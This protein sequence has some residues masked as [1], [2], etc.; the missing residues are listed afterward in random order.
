MAADPLLSD[1]RRWADTVIR[2]ELAAP[3]A[4]TAMRRELGQFPAEFLLLPQADVVLDIVMPDRSRHL[5]RQCKGSLMR[6]RDGDSGVT[7]R[8]FQARHEVAEEAALRDAGRLQARGTVAIAWAVPVSGALPAGRFWNA[9][10]TRTGCV[11]P[12]ILNAPWKLNSDRSALTGE[13]WN[14]ALMRHAASLVARSLPELARKRDPARPVD[15]LPRELERRDDPSAPLH[16]AM[17]REVRCVRFLADGMAGLRR[18]DELHRPPVDDAR[19]Q[20]R[21]EHAASAEQRCA[22]VHHACLRSRDRISRLERLAKLLSPRD[23]R[24]DS[25]E[26]EAPGLPIPAEEAD[27]EAGES[28][29]RL[30][31][32]RSEDWLGAIADAEPQRGKAALLLAADLAEKDPRLRHRL[33]HL[34]IIPTQDDSLAKAEQVVMPGGAVPAGRQAVHPDLVADEAIRDVLSRV[35]RVGT[36]DDDAWRS[37]LQETWRGSAESRPDACERGWESLLAAPD[38]VRQRFLSEHADRLRF[39]TRSGEWK[40]RE[41]VLLPGRVVADTEAAEYPGVLLDPA[42]VERAGALLAAVGVGDRPAERWVREDAVSWTEPAWLVALD[43]K[44]AAVYRERK[45]PRTNPQ[46]GTLGYIRPVAYPAGLGLLSSLKGPSKARLTAVLLERLRTAP[47]RENHV[48]GRGSDPTQNKYPPIP[49]PDPAAWFLWQEGCVQLGQT[50]VTLADVAA[51]QGGLSEEEREVLGSVLPDASVLRSRWI[52]GWQEPVGKDRAAWQALLDPSLVLPPELRRAAWEAAARRRHAPR[53][54]AIGTE[55]PPLPLKEVVVASRPADLA[56]A[57]KAGLPCVLLSE[58]AAAVWIKQGAQDARRLIAV[59]AIGTPGDWIAAAR[60]LPGLA[61]FITGD[62]PSLGFVDKV[63]RVLR[64]IT[65]DGD[66]LSDGDRLLVS[67]HWLRSTPRKAV[68]RR[69]LEAIAAQQPFSA[70]FEQVFAKLDRSEIDRRRAAVR[71]ETDLPSRLLKAVRSAATL[72]ERLPPAARNVLHEHVTD[73]QLATVFLDLQGSAALRELEHEL[74]DAGLAPPARWGTDEARQFVLAL[75]FPLSFAGAARPKLP[76][77]EV[78]T[79]PRPLPP[80]HHYQEE[81]LAELGEVLATKQGRRRAVLSLPTGAGKTRVAVEAAV[82][83]IL[84]R[85]EERPLVLWVAQ[86]E[87]LGEQAVDAFRHVWRMKGSPDAD[88]R[89]VRLWGGQPTPPESEPDRPTVVVTLI[90]TARTRLAGGE[91]PWLAEAAMVVIDESHHAIAP[92]YTDLLGALGLATGQKRSRDREPILLGLTATPFRT[93]D[94]EDS[95]LLAQRFDCR[96][97]PREQATLYDK[98]RQEGFLAAVTMEPITLTQPFEL[99]AEELKLFQGFHDLPPAALD[100][101]SKLADRNEAI[102]RAIEASSERSIL[103][104]ANTVQ[105]AVELTARLSLRGIRARVVSSETDLSAR[106]E[107]IAAFKRSE[108]RVMCNAAV[109]TTGFDAPGVEMILISRPVF[110][111]VRF[112]QMVGRG[113]RGPRNGGTPQCRVVTVRDNIDVYKDRDPLEWWRRHYG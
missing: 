78:V 97:V 21:W 50:I 12:G 102:L 73:D 83:A 9:F 46:S 7:W 88:L 62:G 67:R 71:A 28:A 98:L 111:P 80:L 30:S 77:E 39:R 20:E 66:L 43:Q 64:D 92:S 35:F 48:G 40:R 106:R 65:E 3:D 25:E 29:P 42:F 45:K 1:L 27:A 104:F 22:I 100:R 70:P 76:A 81:V 75:G 31:R 58:D 4:A 37:L 54:V 2:A 33:R 93:G 110:S 53:E 91:A 5:G 44:A 82:G 85:D 41:E 52:E 17:W 11:V 84:A 61:E 113:L 79:G 36:M 95:R 68:L 15:A 32:W 74:R 109:F 8:V 47:R 14:A 87:E 69:L 89:I 10:P 13:A 59:S 23:T 103:L 94:E 38:A 90:E 24:S 16:D 96:V 60:Y 101:L 34:P 56:L 108:V 51:L 112:M 55:A 107:A 49:A 57:E 26:E 6:L 19:L 63:Q 99:T 18:P 105:H 72:K 86:T